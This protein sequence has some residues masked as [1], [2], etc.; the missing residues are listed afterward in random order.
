MFTFSCA[1]FSLRTICNL[2]TMNRFRRRLNKVLQEKY[3]Y[4]MSFREVGLLLFVGYY[5]RGVAYKHFSVNSP[6]SPNNTMVKIS[7]D[8]IE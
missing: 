1:A 8:L 6:R 4:T 5:R 3:L 7:T 2:K